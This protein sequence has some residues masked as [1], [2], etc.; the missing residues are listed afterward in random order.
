MLEPLDLDALL[1]S[2]PDD[3]L[4]AALLGA[5]GTFTGEAG[6]PGASWPEVVAFK[7][8]H[9]VEPDRLCNYGRAALTGLLE[10][11]RSIIPGDVARG[12]HGWTVR[13]VTR[14][15]ELISAGCAWTGDLD[16]LEA[17]LDEIKPE[18]GTSFDAVLAWAI[19][20]ANG[21]VACGM[22]R[23]VDDSSTDDD[24]W[25]ARPVL[26]HIRDYAR[27]KRVSPWALLGVTCA[28]VVTAIPPRV[29]LPA[30]VGSVA[31]LNLY[32]AVVG[33]SG[34]GKG[35]AESAARDALDTGHLEV[36]TLGSGEGIAHLYAHRD[37]GSVVRDRDAVLF[38]APEVDN[39]TALG[40]RRGATLL[41]QLRMAWSGERLGFAYADPKKALPIE[42]HTY[43]LTLVLG[44]QPGR[45]GPLLEDTDA[46]TP[47]RFV[48]LPGND[49]DTP[50]SPPPCPEQLAWHQP[51]KWPRDRSGRYVLAVPDVAVAEI[52][53]ARVARLRGESDALDG[54]ALLAR[55]KLAAALAVLDG[56]DHVDESDWDLAG[57]VMAVSDRTRA[58]VVRHL[59]GKQEATNRA[60]GEAEAD[61]AVVV[62][63]RVEAG[64]VARV[65][66]QIIKHLLEHGDTTW[67]VERRRVA[68]RDRGYFEDAVEALD[69]AGAVTVETLDDGQLLRL[70]KEAS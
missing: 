22:H 32:V 24:F 33:A 39:L 56:R 31:S 11:S 12:R 68:M 4:V 28:R 44:V 62:S 34:L 45:A 67:S 36:F 65:A 61:R 20:N 50:V 66:Q 9:A 15:V 38:T 25:T 3:D 19:N 17:R 60:R 64:A 59:A 69:A 37:K 6:K 10:D 29:V 8:E 54:H 70:T 48:W 40:D 41:P 26:T 55:L 52:D 49:P 58:A 63:G 13:S 43:R 47:Q 23:P 16:T 35:T 46:G 57:T 5:G 18:G 14:A 1:E 42:A 53:A 2:E 30:L 7:A 21:E 27:A 51:S